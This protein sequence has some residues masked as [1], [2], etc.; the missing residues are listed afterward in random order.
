MAFVAALSAPPP[1]PP[2]NQA[3]LSAERR[4]ELERTADEASLGPSATAP[5]LL[6]AARARATLGNR[7][8]AADAYLRA[9]D[10]STAADAAVAALSGYSD[11]M[12]RLGRAEEAATGIKTAADRL[13]RAGVAVDAADVNILIAKALTFS[14]PSAA[15]AMY[16]AVLASDA[17]EF[18]AQLGRGAALTKLERASEA[19]RAFVAAAQLAP[20]PDT[21]NAVYAAIEAVKQGREY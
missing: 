15:L 17:G 20:D 16:E 9:A 6:A 7:E 14:D 1:P 21:K 5:Q 4:A 18:R 3:K 10:T 12:I 2:P 8:S 11:A 13:S 19:E